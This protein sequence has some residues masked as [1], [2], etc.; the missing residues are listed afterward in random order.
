MQAA[1]ST[2]RECGRTLLVL[3][4]VTGGDAARLYER[5]GWVRVGDIPG[6]A[7]MP[8]GGLCSATVYY[9]N[10]GVNSRKIKT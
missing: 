7:L 6:Y 3:D 9:R 8:Q 2:A 10:L 4:A 1:E 5:L